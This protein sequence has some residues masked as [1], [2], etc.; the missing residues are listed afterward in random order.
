MA[1][2]SWLGSQ[3]R[4]FAMWASACKLSSETKP[5]SGSRSSKTVAWRFLPFC[6]IK[7]QPTVSGET[8][9]QTIKVNSTIDNL[10]N[11]WLIAEFTRFGEQAYDFRSRDS[12]PSSCASVHK[13]Q[14]V[15]SRGMKAFETTLSFSNCETL[16]TTHAQQVQL[17]KVNLLS[18]NGLQ[19]GVAPSCHNTFNFRSVQRCFSLFISSSSFLANCERSTEFSER[20]F[21]WINS[22]IILRKATLSCHNIFVSLD[23]FGLSWAFG[24][25]AWQKFSAAHDNSWCASVRTFCCYMGPAKSEFS[26]KLDLWKSHVDLSSVNLPAWSKFSKFEG[27]SLFFLFEKKWEVHVAKHVRISPTLWCLKVK[28]L[29]K[30]QIYISTLPYISANWGGRLTR[31]QSSPC[32]WLNTEI[33]SDF[34]QVNAV[35]CFPNDTSQGEN[36]MAARITMAPIYCTLTQHPV[37]NPKLVSNLKITNDNFS[38]KLCS[39]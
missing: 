11:T 8:R 1:A 6:R 26:V 39:E 16:W 34:T 28:V 23:L 9:H 17:Q 29:G 31:L 19:M 5:Q 4:S 20:Q 30:K 10:S 36:R 7:S 21:V 24:R 12:V 18:Q 25:E 32:L 27:F 14:D 15:S 13:E 2:C 35:L 38:W 33:G 3:H 37:I 22:D